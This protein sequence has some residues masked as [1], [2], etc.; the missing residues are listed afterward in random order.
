LFNSFLKGSFQE[1]VAVVADDIVMDVQ[2][3]G[4]SVVDA[5]ENVVGVHTDDRRATV[6]VVMEAFVLDAGTN[7][8]SDISDA[9]SVVDA[10]VS[11]A[12]GSF[13]SG[14]MVMQKK[15]PDKEHVMQ[16]KQSLRKGIPYPGGVKQY[17]MQQEC[18]T[19]SPSNSIVYGSKFWIL[20]ELNCLVLR[21]TV[22]RKLVLRKLILVEVT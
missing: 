18:V 21:C 9:E 10:E 7:S 4:E 11:C 5:R 2:M 15:A 17:V 19:D 3:D 6:A 13:D 16:Q 8:S 14:K 1:S 12:L 22:V 20:G